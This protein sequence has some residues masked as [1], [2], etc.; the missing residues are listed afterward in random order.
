VQARV[1]ASAGWD[2]LRSPRVEPALRSPEGDVLADRGDP[3]TSA[4]CWLSGVH[5]APA[6]PETSTRPQRVTSPICRNTWALTPAQASRT[7][8]AISLPPTSFHQAPDS[9]CP[10]RS[11]TRSRT[12][13]INYGSGRWS[14]TARS[15]ATR[16][17]IDN[18]RDGAF[19]RGGLPGN[20]ISG[21]HHRA[22]DR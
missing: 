7:R 21:R 1:C 2:P 5:G 3:K 8:T 17:R 14:A 4:G 13:C 6:E 10:P 22:R 12:A 11:T 9:V 16:Q 15:E 18:G 20:R 19:R